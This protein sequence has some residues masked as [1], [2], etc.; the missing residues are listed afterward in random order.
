MID[1]HVHTTNSD[2]R[3]KKEEIGDEILS[4]KM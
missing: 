2:G 4:T 3:L 1:L